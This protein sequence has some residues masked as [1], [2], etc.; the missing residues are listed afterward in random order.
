VVSKKPNV[1]WAT[2][3]LAPARRADK[4]YFFEN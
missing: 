1:C 3:S 4:R 2:R